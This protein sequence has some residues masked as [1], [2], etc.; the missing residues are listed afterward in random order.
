MQ[1]IFITLNYGINFTYVADGD[2]ILKNKIP[3]NVITCTYILSPL[4]KTL[5]KMNL[6]CYCDEDCKLAC[7]FN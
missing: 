7:Q 3:L 5:L 4:F 2:L 6:C 1:T